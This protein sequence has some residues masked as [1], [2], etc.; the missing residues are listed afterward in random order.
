MDSWLR[1]YLRYTEDHEAP[2]LFHFWTGLTMISAALG[3]KV[4]MDRGYYVLYPNLF[5]V[6]VAG[7]ALCRK[8]TAME[9]GV[10]L[11]KDVETTRIVSGIASRE[12]FL[13]EFEFTSTDGSEAP[14]TLSF[15][16]ELAVFLTKDAFGTKMI[17]TL[18]KL[19][20]CPDEYSYRTLG[21]GDV[22][23]R[24][25]HLT[26]LMGT[27]PEKLQDCL[28]DS[29]FGG[30]LTSRMLFVFQS[31]TKRKNAIPELSQEIKDLKELLRKDIGVI[32]QLR[33]EF[34]MT[35]EAKDFFTRWY[36]TIE[37]PGDK[38]LDGYYGRKHDHALRVAMLL[39]A[40]QQYDLVIDRDIISAAIIALDD[41]EQYM[42]GAFS[43][44]GA[45]EIK[46]DVDRVI[47]MLQ[48][49]KRIAHSDLLKKNYRYLNAD[50]FR[51][52]MDTIMQAGWVMR[53]PEKPTYY[54]WTGPGSG[55]PS[56]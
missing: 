52:V 44:V 49:F 50:Q 16:E 54:L 9:L 34:T 55:E 23:I 27:Q 11:L 24:N 37:P 48:K 56:E 53:D 33:G 13:A 28:P 12:K 18:T 4:Y 22:T 39:S 5:T 10:A 45:K 47:R 41:L 2:E 1:K 6:I 15:E 3:R 21:R 51:V 26:A 8:T 7:S 19:F 14:A 42:P 20:N 38:R 40:S 30:G 43:N 29:A 46:S 35:A 31:S 17:D 25:V 32:A 36:D